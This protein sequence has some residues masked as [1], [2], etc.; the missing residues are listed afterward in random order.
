MT[1][2]SFVPIPI[3]GEEYAALVQRCA[4]RLWQTLH[5]REELPE[6]RNHVAAILAEVRRTLDSYAGASTTV[7]DEDQFR[8]ML[9]KSPLW[10]QDDV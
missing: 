4:I 3:D 1:D 8:A 2:R 6:C 7:Y 9:A 10:P 5:P